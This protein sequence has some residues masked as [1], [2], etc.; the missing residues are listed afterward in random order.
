MGSGN[1]TALESFGL[2][3]GRVARVDTATGNRYKTGTLFCNSII[4]LIFNGLPAI[5]LPHAGRP[6]KPLLYFFIDKRP[7]VS[8]I[9]FKRPPGTYWEY[10]D[11]QRARTDEKKMERRNAIYSAA[12]TLLKRDGYENVSFNGIAAEAGFTKSNLYRYFSSR[13]EIFLNIFSTLFAGWV[14]DCLKR[15]GKLK[16]DET[17]ERFAKAY[18]RSMKD[19]TQFLD[20]TPMLFISLERNSSFEQLLAFKKASMDRLSKI[21]LEV[22][23]IYPALNIQKAFKYL[24]LTFAATINY[25]TASTEN[26][27][28]NKIYRMPEFKELKPNFEKD[29]AAAIEI[30]L[31]GLEV[32]QKKE[33]QSRG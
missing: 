25:W 27:A 8:Y 16:Q 19:H 2:N 1:A 32:N 20:L 24:N 3:A 30:I 33:T 12:F 31:R 7:V 26:E 15:L 23:R 22:I 4:R 28:L 14:D 5:Y 11:W 9:G 6:G 18:V 17:I 29:L 10:M 13:E 21:A